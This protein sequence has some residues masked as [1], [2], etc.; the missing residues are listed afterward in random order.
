MTQSNEVSGGNFW[1]SSFS[2]VRTFLPPCDFFVFLPKQ[3]AEMRLEG[4]V[5]FCRHQVILGEAY[6]TRAIAEKGQGA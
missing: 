4:A 3:V 2:D 6:Y 5:H 1:E